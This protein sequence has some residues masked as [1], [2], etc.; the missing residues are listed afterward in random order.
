MPLSQQRPIL[1]AITSG[2]TTSR[3]TPDDHDF[4]RILH[5]AEGAV[6]ARISLFQIREKNL[7]ARVLFELVA[8]ATKI[9]RDSSTRLLVNDRFDVALAAGADGV[10]LTST[11]L[12]PRVA[13][14][15]CGPEFLIGVSTHSLETARDARDG[16]A[17][18]AVF[19]PV[20]ET[21]SKRVYGPPQGLDKLKQVAT[22]LRGFPV[23]AIGG[24]T[25]ENAENCFAA[26]ASGIAGIRLFDAFNP[27]R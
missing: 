25:L 14:G 15:I 19:G 5:L 22:E 26:G 6:A 24:I 2:A 13:R 16:S 7:G 10:Q 1:Y 27:T 8:C 11:S 4:T 20:F 12:P 3:T 9:T 23:I 21:E 18:F 17:D